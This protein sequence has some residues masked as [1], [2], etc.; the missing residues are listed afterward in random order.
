MARPTAAPPRSSSPGPRPW[1]RIEA[2]APLTYDRRSARERGRKNQ[3]EFLS[4]VVECLCASRGAAHRDGALDGGDHERRKP[5]GAGGRDALLAQCR[6]HDPLP[7]GE[8][9]V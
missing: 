9:A 1:P 7:I 2:D 6:D 4:D 5:P 3:F 8:D